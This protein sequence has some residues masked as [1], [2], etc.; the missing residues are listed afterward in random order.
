[1]AA[2][3]TPSSDGMER[4]AGEPP[5][6]A[7]GDLALRLMESAQQLHRQ[8]DPEETLRAVVGAAVRLI[9][10]AQEGSLSLVAAGRTL[11]TEA[12]TSALAADVDK[13]QEQVGEGPCLDAVYEQHTIVVADTAHERRWPRFSASAC[14]AGVGSILALQLF[15]EGDRLGA[16]NLYARQPHAFDDDSQH[17]GQMFAAHAAIAYSTARRQVQLERAV[18]SRELIG[19][20]QGIL[21]ERHKVTSDQA[22][23]ILVQASQHGNV[24]LRDIADRLVRTGSLTDSRPL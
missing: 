20:A 2:N 10:G 11:L 15:V 19:Q 12:A 21:M 13:L 8:N 24:K 9:P 3:A 22:F 7:S 4:V 6:V 14:E 18:H 16:L 23:A 1:M 5:R 17:V